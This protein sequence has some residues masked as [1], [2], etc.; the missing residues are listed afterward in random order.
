MQIKW[1]GE[2]R[3][4]I[5]TK[6]AV[7]LTG[8][9]TTIND[10]KL[11]GPGEYEVAGVEAF[12]IAAEIYLFRV[13]DVGIAYFDS[14]NRTLSADEVKALS[15]ISIAIIPVGGKEVIDEN[16]AADIIKA[17]EP[18]IVIPIE[19]ENFDKFCKLLGK[20]QEPVNAY[21]ITKQQISLMEG[22]ITVILNH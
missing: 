14:I 4:E 17:I 12:G 3:V 5:E 6:G 9:K 21:K 1:K 19:S 10:V 8:E 11:S 7:I 2:N 20:C 13:E 22:M 18:T 15:D 16:K